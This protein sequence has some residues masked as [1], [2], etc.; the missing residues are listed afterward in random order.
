MLT[1][2]QILAAIDAAEESAFGPKTSEIASDRADALDRYLGKP[3][4]DE[5]AGRSQVVSR[6]ISDVVEGV[7]ANVLKPFIGGDRVVVFNPRGPEDEQAAEQESDYINFVVMERNNGFVVLNSA[8]KDALLLRNGYLKCGWTTRNDITIENYVG[9]T[10]DELAMLM[11]DEDVEVVAH[12]EYPDPFGQGAAQQI[13]QMPAQ[14]PAAMPGMPPAPGNGPMLPQQ[15]PMLHDV[16]VHRKRPTEYVE[17]LPAPPDEILVSQRSVEPSIQQ[18]D[19]VQHRTHKTLS[20]LRELGYKVPDD[21]VDGEDGSE[22]IEDFARSAFSSSA[23]QWTDPTSIMA[24]RLVLFKESWIR[25]DKDGDG[26]AELRRICSVGK[27]LL[28]DEDADLIPI[29]CFTPVLMPHRHLGVSIYDLVKDIAQIKT[30]MLRSHLDN[31]YL[32]NNAEKVVNVDA[33]ENMDDWLI[34]RPGGMKRVRGSV[35]DA[36]MPLVV[37]DTGAG[38]LQTLEYLDTIRENRTGYTKTAEGV[39]SDSLATQTLGELQMQ[40]SQSGVRLEMIARTIAETGLRDLFR[41][42]HAITL[43]HGTKAEKVRLRNQWIAVNPREWVRRTDLSISVG[44][45]STTGPQQMQNLQMLGMAQQQAMPL[46]IVTPEN[47]YNTLSKLATAAGFKNPEEFF[48]KPQPGAQPP[49]HDD[50]LVQAEKIKQQ[51]AMQ[52]EPMKLQHQAGL[53]QAKMQSNVQQTQA[54]A[55]QVAMLKQFEIEKQMELERFKAEQQAMLEKYKIDKQVE[56]DILK[57]QI[58]GSAQVKAAYKTQT[59]D[60][61]DEVDTAQQQRDQFAQSHAS[62]TA[63][64]M[65]MVQR[66]AEDAQQPAVLHRGPDGRVAAVQRGNRMMQVQRGSDGRATGIQ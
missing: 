59:G 36:A 41:I 35:A 46:G 55:Q 40:Q 47:V 14:P 48:T 57:A 23:D 31:R 6:D 54:E 63:Q 15:M 43:K 24:R 51:T 58:A 22:T 10:D 5:Q 29:A 17:V 33:I 2:D 30:A 52:I 39:R 38:A 28:A 66:M 25:I 7:T 50:P 1:A 11:E 26:I 20:E 45:G 53:E 21:I 65:E 8:V 4:G 61:K 13:Q 37:P 64:L 9:K 44:L 18:A 32:L 3:Y 16:K 56:A 42:V 12:T 62:M 19:F 49:Q 60:D 34:S 27:N